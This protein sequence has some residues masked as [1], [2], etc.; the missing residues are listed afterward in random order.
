MEQL[1][2]VFD[3]KI[4]GDNIVNRKPLARIQT[5]A[6]LG[7]TRKNGRQLAFFIFII[8]IIIPVGSSCFGR[9]GIMNVK[10]SVEIE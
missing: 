2:M 1:V 5:E 7:S 3:T 4:S 8:S 10:N 9:N 6:T